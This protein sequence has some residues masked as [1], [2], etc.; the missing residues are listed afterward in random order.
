MNEKQQNKPV[1]LGDIL[2][3]ETIAEGQQGDGIAKVDN[4]VIIIK[5]A[6]NKKTYEIQITGVYSTYAIAKIR[7]LIKEDDEED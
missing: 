1:K 7:R 6:L 4:F 5:G 3:C 2:T